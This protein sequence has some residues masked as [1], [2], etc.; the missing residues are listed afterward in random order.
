ME[1]EFLF[2]EGCPSDGARHKMIVYIDHAI[3]KF[4]MLSNDLHPLY[5]KWFLLLQEFEFGIHDER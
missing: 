4:F 5:L 3:W 1:L 2:C